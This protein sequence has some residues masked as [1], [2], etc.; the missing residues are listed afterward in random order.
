[1][2]RIAAS[3]P[4]LRLP[5]AASMLLSCLLL[6]VGFAAWP[7]RVQSNAAK[8]A[9]GDRGTARF[10]VLSRGTR[11]AAAHVRFWLPPGY[12]QLV[13]ALEGNAMIGS[14]RQHFN[15]SDGSI[16]SVELKAE[17]QARSSPPRRR[18]DRLQHRRGDKPESGTYVK[19]QKSGRVGSLR[20][21]VG[22]SA[23][24]N[25]VTGEL[26][27]VGIAVRRAPPRFVPAKRKWAVVTISISGWQSCG[28][29]RSQTRNTVSRAIRSV[30]IVSGGARSVSGVPTEPA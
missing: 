1:M 11:P 13:G 21:Y 15:R 3:T 12:R 2:N 22:S 24:R 9:G 16:C 27:L 4:R 20:W 5:S 23:T 7:E 6:L 26:E 19:V 28:P 29:G 8:A 30:R 10:R 17:G 14:Y 25:P 18:G